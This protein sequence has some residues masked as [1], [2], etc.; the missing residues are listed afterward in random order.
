MAGGRDCNSHCRVCGGRSVRR[1]W[2]LRFESYPGPFRLWRC[3]E[4]GVAFN[5]PQ[6]PPDSIRGQYDADYYI[7]SL[8]P[9]RR[10]A[11]AAQLYLEYL[12]PLEGMDGRRLLDVGC[13][14][15]DLLALARRRGWDVQ[16]IEISPEPARRALAEHGVPVEIGTIEEKGLELRPFDVAIATDVIEHV[17]S[18]R[19]FLAAMHAVLRP[20]GLAI[21]ETP[22]LGGFWSKV[23]GPCWI[24]LNR[25]H[26]F[27]FTP[28]SLMRLMRSCG[29]NSCRATSCTHTAYAQWGNRPELG[30]FIR[31]LPAALRW[32]LQ[33]GLNDATPRSRGTDLWRNPPH[34][35]EEALER[36]AGAAQRGDSLRGMGRLAGDNLCVTGRAGARVCH[37]S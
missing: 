26:V 15:G 18:P 6:L 21:L 3:G 32:R 22:N 28:S 35:L 19:G 25:F 24:G 4:C 16:G 33:R 8:P 29:F 34:C 5:W 14:R 1:L 30:G 13:G 37:A 17:T 9:G 27:L 2:S 10:W 20:G 23:G 36:I 11:R 31:P 12:H 7:F